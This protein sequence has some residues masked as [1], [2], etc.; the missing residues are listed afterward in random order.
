MYDRILTLSVARKGVQV[1]FLS[2]NFE[3]SPKCPYLDIV[4]QRAQT[5]P[6][7]YN[8]GEIFQEFEQTMPDWSA[9]L[10]TCTCEVTGILG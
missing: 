10:L 1:S 3:T 8:I 7:L 6:S 4:K 5:G 9:R 2:E